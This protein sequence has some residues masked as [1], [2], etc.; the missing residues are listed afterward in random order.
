MAITNLTTAEKRV[1]T[2]QQLRCSAAWASGIQKDLIFLSA[3]NILLSITAVLGNTLI[4]VALRKV[5]SLHPPSKLLYRSLAITDLCVGLITAP[6]NVVY[7]VAVAREQ[8]NLCR[9][10][11]SSLVVAGYTLCIGDRNKRGQISRPVVRAE[12]QTS[13]NFKAN[14]CDCSY[15]LDYVRCCFIILPFESANHHLVWPFNYSFMFRSLSRLVHKDFPKPSSSSNSA[16]GPCPRRANKSKKSTEHGT[17]PK[18]SVQRTVGAVY[19]NSLL[20]TV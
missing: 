3:F 2:F 8:W 14:I 20:F 6:L 7:S 5:S 19:I 9:Y 13:C 11:L 18:G 16:T 15:L 12:I 17:I 1:E 4:L 10:T